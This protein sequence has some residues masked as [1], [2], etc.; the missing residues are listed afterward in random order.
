MH[1]STRPPA[2]FARDFGRTIRSAAGAGRERWLF[3]ALVTCLHTVAVT[4]A[5]NAGPAAVTLTPVLVAEFANVL[6]TNHPALRAARSRVSAAGASTA[7]VRRWSDPTARFGGAVFDSRGSKAEEEGDLIYG[8]EQKLPIFGKESAARSMAEAEA[9]TTTERAEAQFQLLRRDLARALFNLSLAEQT[10][11][12][13]REDVAWLEQMNA[14][15]E[16]RYRG[17][18]GSP[19]DILRVQNER[20]KRAEQLITDERRRDDA[21]VVVN[22]LLGRESTSALPELALPEVARPIPYSARLVDFALKYEPRLKVLDRELRQ[23]VAVAEATRRS[24]RPDLGLGLEGRQYSGDGGFREGM[25]TLSFSLPWFNRARYRHDLERDHLLIQATQHERADN[26]LSVREEVHHL[27]VEIDAARREALLYRDQI[28]PRSTT[29]LEAAQ[30]A[31]SNGR[32]MLFDVM[33]ARRMLLEG[34]LMFARAVAM[35]WIAMSELVLCCGVG[36]LE[37]L[38]MI[39]ASSPDETQ[40][41]PSKP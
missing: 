30:I 36:D 16:A 19:V 21:R 20:S 26:E 11:A 23:K 39:G 8:L 32:G 7:G 2:P 41:P 9:A 28:I 18:T 15:M 4:A 31:W 5:T 37:A 24:Q 14:G 10:V 38:E 1:S 13:G 40:T 25:F 17:G 6:R 35:Q 29:A 33:E 12:V 22:R 27:T 34:R 3:V